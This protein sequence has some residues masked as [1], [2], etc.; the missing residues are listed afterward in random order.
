[1]DRDSSRKRPR[2]QRV[3]LENLQLN[4]VDEGSKKLNDRFKAAS[5]FILNEAAKESDNAYKN[6]LNLRIEINDV[7]PGTTIMFPADSEDEN[8]ELNNEWALTS[9][10]VFG[11]VVEK[12]SETTTIKIFG[13]LHE[14]ETEIHTAGSE[15]KVNN[16]LAMVGPIGDNIVYSNNVK[17][18]LCHDMRICLEK[19]MCADEV[20]A[21][22]KGKE[23]TNGWE[24]RAKG[25]LL[26]GIPDLDRT[27][28]TCSLKKEGVQRMI[29]V[30]GLIRLLHWERFER[31][32]DDLDFKS[33]HFL[34]VCQKYANKSWV[35][36]QN[37]V[38]RIM[39]RPSLYL[40]TH[41]FSPYLS[42]LL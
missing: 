8:E 35:F 39:T 13:Y 16:P 23:K 27:P 21:E 20:R 11:K 32:I 40:P 30:G 5:T 24:D 3:S 34:E 36:Y 7:N 4:V 15:V 37:P 42:F 22:I 12:K 41:L 26:F 29:V 1:M 31:L 25:V 18:K 6:E 17:E 14:P 2:F 19:R 10:W 28:R 38:C 9:N 33:T